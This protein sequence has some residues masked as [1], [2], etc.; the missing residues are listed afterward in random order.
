MT[1]IELYAIGIPLFVP[2]VELLVDWHM[3]Q[4][5]LTYIT[6]SNVTRAVDGQPSQPFANNRK[7]R[8]AL[9]HW[10][11]FNQPYQ[12]PHVQQFS[13]VSDLFER[14]RTADLGSISRSMHVHSAERLRRLKSEWLAIMLNVLSHVPSHPREVPQ[15]AYADAMDAIYGSVAYSTIK[16]HDDAIPCH[17]ESMAE[18]QGSRDL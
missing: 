4:H 8:D 18:A 17:R 5:L 11:Q 7:D 12:M 1:F 14:L 9:L 16:R 15:A 6:W 10:F 3:T 2:T 13:S